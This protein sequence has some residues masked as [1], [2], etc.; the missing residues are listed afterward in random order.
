MNTAPPTNAMANPA[1]TPAPFADQAAAA[2]P[3][4]VADAAEPVFEA[5]PVVEEDSDLDPPS[6][7]AERVESSVK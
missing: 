1:I 5:V 6:T 2:F 7:R 3:D 4:S